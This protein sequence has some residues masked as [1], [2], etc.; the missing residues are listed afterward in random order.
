MVYSVRMKKFRFIALILVM[1]LTASCSNLLDGKFVVP[2]GKQ[3]PYKPNVDP[4]EPPKDPSS[5][6]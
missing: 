4:F 2:E 3:S 6:L 1:L 5:R